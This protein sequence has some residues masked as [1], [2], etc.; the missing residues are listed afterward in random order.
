MHTVAE[1]VK[2]GIES[3]GGSATIYQVAETLPQDILDKMHAPAK[4][5][6]PVIQPADLP[7]FD[8]FVFGIPTRYGNM[9][10]QLKVRAQP[11]LSPLLPADAPS[12]RAGVLRCDGPAL[13]AGCARG[14][15]RVRLRLDRHAGRRPG[16]D[17]HQR[18]LHLRP[19]R[20]HLRAPRL[21]Q[22]LRPARQRLGGPRR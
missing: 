2:S 3:A 19:P 15:V 6:Y 17:R 16:D 4:A 22:V 21:Q 8:A 14:Q 1:T 13:G 10:A 7:Q 20:P 5:D 11:S 9:P 18:A 12:S